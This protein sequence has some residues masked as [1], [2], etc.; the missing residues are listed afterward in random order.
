KLEVKELEKLSYKTEP[1]QKIIEKEKK[2][3]E[4]LII[5]PLDFDLINRDIVM[6]AWIKNKEEREENP[7]LEYEQEYIVEQAEFRNIIKSYPVSS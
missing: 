5:V 3:K 1:M 2:F 4:K 7:N 6:E